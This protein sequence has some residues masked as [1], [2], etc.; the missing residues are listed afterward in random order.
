MN[1]LWWCHQ[2][3]ILILAIYC[4]NVSHLYSKNNTGPNMDPC[5][6]PQVI[7]SKSEVTR[8]ISTH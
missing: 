8:S 1:I 3:I 5:G 6:T 2:Q 7:L 4:T